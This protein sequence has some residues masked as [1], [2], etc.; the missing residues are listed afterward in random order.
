MVLDGGRGGLGRGDEEGLHEL[1]LLWE[2]AAAA[3]QEGE[4]HGRGGARCCRRSSHHQEGVWRGCVRVGWRGGRVLLGLASVKIQAGR[5]TK[6]SRSSAS[7]L[8]GFLCSCS[9]LLGLTTIC[10]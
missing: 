7:S 2:E 3:Q 1:L 4:E 6:P 9:S 10:A 8:R 5:E